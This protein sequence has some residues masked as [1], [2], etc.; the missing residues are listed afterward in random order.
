MKTRWRLA[1]KRYLILEFQRFIKKISKPK[2]AQQPR[3]T[4]QSYDRTS[5][6]HYKIIIFKNS[7]WSSIS[8]NSHRPSWYLLVMETPEL[9]K[10]S[11]LLFPVLTLIK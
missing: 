10:K 4:L 6:G 3:G 5:L 1:K 8:K 7:F 2:A 11:V 9:C